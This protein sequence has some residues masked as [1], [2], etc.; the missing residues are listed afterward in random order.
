[1]AT[2]PFEKLV[3]FK[4]V[5]TSGFVD[6]PETTSN[7][8]VVDEAFLKICGA[9]PS[10]S[11]GSEETTGAVGSDDGEDH[12]DDAR[13]KIPTPI[14]LQRRETMSGNIVV[15]EPT[16]VNVDGNDGDKT[17][18]VDDDDNINASN[19]P[20]IRSPQ[21]LPVAYWLQRRLGNIKVHTLHGSVI[22]L[23]YKLRMKD[24]SNS[25]SNTIEKRSR[26]DIAVGSDSSLATSYHNC[27]ELDMLDGKPIMVMILILQHQILDSKSEIGNVNPL[28]ELSAL[29]LIYQHNPTVSVHVINTRLISMCRQSIYCVLPYYHDG[30]LFELCQSISSSSSKSTTTSGPLE[31]PLARFLFRQIM[32]VRRHDHFFGKSII[33]QVLYHVV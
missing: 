25:N 9:K 7:H 4:A 5:R 10:S 3:I 8:H 26:G 14:S 30:S 28:N 19:T 1:M 22:R 6:I 33:L 15:I 24:N 11:L 12:D 16:M 13:M 23:A 18:D 31:E 17:C 2:I 32:Q 20:S 21:D 27:W 29:Q